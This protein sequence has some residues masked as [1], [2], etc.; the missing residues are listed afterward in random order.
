MT[1]PDPR[2]LGDLTR[3]DLTDRP[4][5]AIPL[6]SCE[7]HG[8]HLPLDTDTRLATAFAEGL[9][10]ARTG[11][12]V[13]PPLPFGASWEH[14]G[15]PGLLSVDHDLLSGILVEL[16]RSADWSAGLVVVNGHGG[17]AP[18][19]RAAAA[20]ISAEGRRV[21][22]W[23][24]RPPGADLHAGRT[25]TSLLLALD[26]DAVRADRLAGAHGFDGPLAQVVE[27]GV[28]ALSPSGVL[29]DA[30]HADAAHGARLFEHLIADLI[31]AY[32]RWAG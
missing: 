17:N 10:A 25:E 7:Q 9:A 18:G 1:R 11:V 14:A 20:R 2:R 3:D 32:D 26:R 31:A 15:F 16:A 28:A 24:P 13:A 27:R 8:P 30:R 22:V 5:L 29:G 6:G 19:V 12:L 23:S 21:L 4:V